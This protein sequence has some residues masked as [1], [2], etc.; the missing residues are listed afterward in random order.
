MRRMS[1]ARR[2][3]N[4]IAGLRNT[5]VVLKG[6]FQEIGLFN[7]HMLVKWNGCTGSHPKQTGEQAGVLVLVQH[8]HLDP[9]KAGHRFPIDVGAPDIMRC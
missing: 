6:A 8:L 3:P 4:E 9:L 7:I 1:V 2:A 5:V